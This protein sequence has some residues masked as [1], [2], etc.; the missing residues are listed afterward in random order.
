MLSGN[1]RHRRP[2]QA[3]A[4]LVAAGVTGSAIA[5][6][7]LGATGASAASGTTWDKVAECESGGSWSADTGQRVLRRAAADPGGLGEV[8]RPRL[9]PERRPGQPLAADSRRREGARRPGRRRLGHLRAA[10]RAR[11]GHRLGRRG[12]GRGGRLVEL[13]QL[14]RLIR[15]V[16]FV[17]FIR[18][19]RLVGLRPS[20]AGLRPTRPT[21]SDST[22]LDSASAVSR[23]PP[24]TRRT[25][26]ECPRRL[27]RG[28][29]RQ[30]A[31]RRLTHGTPAVD[32]SD[33]SG[34][35]CGSSAP[36]STATRGT[37]RHRG[38]SADEDGAD[39]D[40]D[41][42]RPTAPHRLRLLRPSRLACDAARDVVDGS[43]TVRVGD[44]LWASP[45]PL[46][47]T[48]DGARSTPRTSGRSA[49][50]RT[51]SFPVRPSTRR[52]RNRAKSSGSSRHASRRMSVL[53]RVRD[54]SQKP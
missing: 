48:A 29:N 13:R 40:A 28:G 11:Q 1:G 27:R 14:L 44:S 25:L 35:E 7:L 33:K 8:R 26:R 50:T 46:A 22:A 49:P 51:S 6:P 39:A 4:L 31:R 3:P 24:P 30:P 38:A 36:R 12:H 43:Y 34:Q 41:A 32:D 45:T 5:I 19:I 16:R 15:L 9:R 2:R 20:S 52:C 17:G 54:E 37:G 21:R 18:V 23:P 42:G 47:S 10:L 53:V